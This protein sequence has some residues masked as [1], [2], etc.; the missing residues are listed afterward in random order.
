M[1]PL[2]LG[3]AKTS[4]SFLLKAMLFPSVFILSEMKKGS[5]GVYMAQLLKKFSKSEIIDV[6]IFC[7][8]SGIVWIK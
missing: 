5:R 4:R 6:F 8:F 3:Q 2:H 7:D 1:S